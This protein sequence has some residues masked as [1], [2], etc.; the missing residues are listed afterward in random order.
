MA[1]GVGLWTLY[2]D[3]RSMGKAEMTRYLITN[4]DVEMLHKNLLP[5]LVYELSENGHC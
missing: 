4:L 5:S 1:F 2:W 3:V